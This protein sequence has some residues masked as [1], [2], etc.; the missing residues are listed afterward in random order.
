M[1]ADLVLQRIVLRPITA[2]SA[3]EVV[4]GLRHDDWAVDY[5]TDG[6]MVICA[7]VLRAL[8][9]GVNYQPPTVIA[10]WTGP[11]QVCVRTNDGETV[12]GGIGFKGGPTN[13]A[14]EIGYGIAESARGHGY[15]TD[16][17][18]ALLQ[19]VSGQDL[20]VTAETEPGNT[21][22]ERV[23]QRCGFVPTHT[24]DDGNL[25]WEVE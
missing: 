4:N 22:S 15:A 19:L 14:I 6:D 9:S 2:G 11:W 1:S 7:L 8:D 20:R 25:W 5:P 3:A 18:R 24:A 12:I 13:G 17:V 21:A 23:L 10:P 16:A